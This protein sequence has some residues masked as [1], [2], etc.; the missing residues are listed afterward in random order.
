MFNKVSISVDD[1]SG[2]ITIIGLEPESTITTKMSG[3]ILIKQGLSEELKSDI[4][5]L[6]LMVEAALRKKQESG[7]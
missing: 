3:E 2:H 6:Y 1:E 5:T 4:F 7:I